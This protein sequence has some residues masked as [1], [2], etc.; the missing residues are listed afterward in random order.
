MNLTIEE[1]RQEQDALRASFKASIKNSLSKNGSALSHG[2]N[3]ADMTQFREEF[4]GRVET[5]EERMA[6]LEKFYHE[7]NQ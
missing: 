4:F 5:V 1:E 6:Y 7:V 2:V 3:K